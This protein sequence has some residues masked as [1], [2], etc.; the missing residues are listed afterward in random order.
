MDLPYS[1]AH[2]AS[3]TDTSASAFKK[4]LAH[5]V[6]CVTACV[7]PYFF[8]L[9]WLRCRDA[10]RID[11]SEYRSS[12][13]FTSTIVC[14]G[15]YQERIKGLLLVPPCNKVVTTASDILRSKVVWCKSLRQ[16]CLYIHRGGAFPFRDP[17]CGFMGRTS[18]A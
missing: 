8:M 3:G 14:S 12:L 11:S 2:H 9:P 6:E 15:I 13:K 1:Q 7:A 4:C 17:D 16:P 10:F 5:F 18:T